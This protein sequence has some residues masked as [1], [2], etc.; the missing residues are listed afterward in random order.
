MLLAF[1]MPG[2]E[3]IIWDRAGGV[4]RAR[5]RVAPQGL[6]AIAFAPDSQ[7]LAVCGELDGTIG[8]LDTLTG[9]PHWT[10]N[11]GHGATTSLAYS[12]DGKT[13]VASHGGALSFLDAATG[14]P[15]HSH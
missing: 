8:V 13:L 11:L 5:A 1:G 6:L 15:H 14:D 3:V 10:A 7:S 9:H 4:Q 12:P 2:G